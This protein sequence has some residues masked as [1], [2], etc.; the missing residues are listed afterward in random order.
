[1]KL[2]LFL[3]KIDCEFVY[4]IDLLPRNELYGDNNLND[5][6][7]FLDNNEIDTTEKEDVTV[8]NKTMIVR[9]IEEKNDKRTKINMPQMEKI[10]NR[11]SYV[12]TKKYRIFIISL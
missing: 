2:Y 1:L 6:S 5:S 12:R 10:F 8:P 4:K 11:I 9:K 7:Y 3:F